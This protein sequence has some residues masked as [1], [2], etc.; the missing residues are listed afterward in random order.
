M[1]PLKRLPLAIS[2]LALGLLPSGAFF[3]WIE[4][5]CS[6]PRAWTDALG[7]PSLPWMRVQWL[8][9]PLALKLAINAGLF[10]AF[11]LS[12]SLLAGKRLSRPAYVIVAGLGVAA[13]MLLWQGT[14]VVA[15]NFPLSLPWIS[16]GLYWTLL[17]VGASTLRPFDFLG[18]DVLLGRKPRPGTLQTG[19]LYRYTRHPLY[20]GILAAV[21]V[22]PFASLDRIFLGMIAMGYLFWAVPREEA[23]L[24]REYGPAYRKYQARVPGF[25]W[26]RAPSPPSL[27]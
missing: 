3:V 2:W 10:A 6:L 13:V 8:D 16:P 21:F 19:G 11:G 4:H 15:W 9:A 22:T 20:L 7:L 27:R 23:K 25:F 14:G 18:I 24:L 17:L 5:Q 1:K 12:H 26:L